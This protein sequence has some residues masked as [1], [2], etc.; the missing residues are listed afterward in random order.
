[1][2]SS[3][4]RPLWHHL[5][6]SFMG[7]GLDPE[8]AQDFWFWTGKPW[9]D[10]KSVKYRFLKILYIF[11]I[12]ALLQSIIPLA[13]IFGLGFL[14]WRWS[15]F[16]YSWMAL[17]GLVVCGAVFIATIEWWKIRRKIKRGTPPL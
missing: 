4:R 10:D 2:K 5:F 9:E 6:F 13:F 1:M 15:G 8:F 17:S 3:H 14:I 11:I 7:R 16:L 12:S